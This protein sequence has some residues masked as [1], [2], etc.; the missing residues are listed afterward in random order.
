MSHIPDP[1]K[2]VRLMPATGYVKTSVTKQTGNQ[3]NG[4]TYHLISA[5]CDMPL[6]ANDQ[7]PR[8]SPS[9]PNIPVS[10]PDWLL[11]LSMLYIVRLL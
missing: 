2:G 6:P 4:F 1:T 10:A 5:A 9:Q 3:Y 7:S 11:Y 8:N